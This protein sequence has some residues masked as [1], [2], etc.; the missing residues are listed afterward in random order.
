VRWRVWGEWQEY[1]EATEHDHSTASEAVK[2]VATTADDAFPDWNDGDRTKFYARPTS[3]ED[4]DDE[5]CP[6]DDPATLVFTAKLRVSSE[7]TVTQK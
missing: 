7:I 2:H 6:E 3:E 4:G 1:D 5:W